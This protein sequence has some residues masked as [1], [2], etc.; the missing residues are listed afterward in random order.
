MFSI[1]GTWMG[2][3]Q[4][5]LGAVGSHPQQC[6]STTELGRDQNV[7]YI[8]TYGMLSSQE[9]QSQFVSPERPLKQT[10]PKETIWRTFL[11]FMSPLFSISK[12]RPSFI[13]EAF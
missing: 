11:V 9:L 13:P 10:N 12:T 3:H 8:P 4:E 6:S 7:S 5:T 2:N 1:V